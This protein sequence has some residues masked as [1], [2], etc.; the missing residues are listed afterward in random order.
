MILTVILN[1]IPYACEYLISSS[2][3]PNPV[4][5]PPST[6]CSGRIVCFPQSGK[7][8][9]SALMSS[10]G[11]SSKK[12]FNGNIGKQERNPWYFIDLCGVADSSDQFQCWKQASERS[13]AAETSEYITGLCPS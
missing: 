7:E 5:W 2:A 3:D 13:E 10:N 9:V 6:S 1:S 8:F 4:D 12:H 11:I